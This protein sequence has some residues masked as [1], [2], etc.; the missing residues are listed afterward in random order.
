MNIFF[1]SISIRRCARA[2]FDKH[3]VKMILEYC[4]LLSAAWFILNEQEAIVH[5]TQNNIYKPTHKNHPCSVWVRQHINNYNYVARLGLELCKE[6]RYRYNHPNTRLHAAEHK[7]IFLINNPPINI[8]TFIIVKVPSNP[9]MFT[10]PMPQAMPDE[11]KYKKKN[12]VHSCVKAYRK[13]YTS[14]H[15]E[16]LVSWTIKKTKISKDRESLDKP[17]WWI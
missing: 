17:K 15:K 16:H 9:K 3:V 10:L 11:C 2:H 14:I 13:Y 6:W 4:Q 8:P 7:L 5:I 1:L 12:S